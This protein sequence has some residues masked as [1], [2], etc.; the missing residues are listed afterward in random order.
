MAKPTI[1][2]LT[3][4]EIQRESEKAMDSVAPLL[5]ISLAEEA[6]IMLVED[7]IYRAPA[8]NV[9]D[10]ADDELDHYTGAGERL[11]LFNDG[12][13]TAMYDPMNSAG[14]KGVGDYDI[15][16]V[17]DDVYG[18]VAG[19]ETGEIWLVHCSCYQM[20]EPLQLTPGVA[21]IDLEYRLERHFDEFGS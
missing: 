13:V 6:P 19:Q 7:R 9:I 18:W 2:T 3:V 8:C 17:L 12:R 15:D 11:A 4:V 16:A 20:C 1:A 21:S 10:V 5:K 14:Y